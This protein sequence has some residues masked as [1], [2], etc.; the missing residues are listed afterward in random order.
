MK[1][2][3]WESTDWGQGQISMKLNGSRQVFTP[4]WNTPFLP[5][6]FNFL[7]YG[8]LLIPDSHWGSHMLF[9]RLPQRNKL[10]TVEQTLNPFPLNHNPSLNTWHIFLAYRIIQSMMQRKEA[11]LLFPNLMEKP[12]SASLRPELAREHIVNG[13]MNNKHFIPTFVR[14][15]CLRNTI[16]SHQHR[17]AVYN[18]WVLHLPDLSTVSIIQNFFTTIG[19]T[20]VNGKELLTKWPLNAAIKFRSTHKLGFLKRPFLERLNSLFQIYLNK[21]HGHFWSGSLVLVPEN[22]ALLGTVASTSKDC[23][24]EKNQLKLKE[25]SGRWCRAQP[26]STYWRTLRSF[27]DAI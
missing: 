1:V 13:L 14:H 11:C 23:C 17:D 16:F 22:L 25:R 21:F 12:N 24:W 4:G 10:L 5:Y 3:I 2:I 9:L 27:S 20:A 6:F 15:G 19:R 7:K 18:A 26:Q 8:Q